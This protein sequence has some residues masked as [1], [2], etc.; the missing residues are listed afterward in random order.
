MYDP[1]I[2][3]PERDNFKN[4][5]HIYRD[6]MHQLRH[7]GF[8]TIVQMI[9]LQKSFDELQKIHRTLFDISQITQYLHICF[10]GHIVQ[11]IHKWGTLAPY[12]QQG[13]EA[14]M[15]TVKGLLIKCTMRG[16]G[17]EGESL[18]KQVLNLNIIR[19]LY[20]LNSDVP[21]AL[22]GDGPIS[23]LYTEFIEISKNDESI[24]E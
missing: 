23:A 1:D 8:F 16:G 3:N 11:M 20:K 5:F 7:M 4:Y 6:S 24:L 19:L 2:S 17:A 10:S 18:S 12:S 9:N 14:L 21:I 22:Y 15:A 13:M